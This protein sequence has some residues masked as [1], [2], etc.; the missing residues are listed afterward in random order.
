MNKYN[1]FDDDL[2][3]E[4]DDDYDSVDPMFLQIGKTQR[5]RGPGDETTIKEE[6]T[7]IKK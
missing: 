5:E 1:R 4:L 6:D 7:T 3:L 2:D